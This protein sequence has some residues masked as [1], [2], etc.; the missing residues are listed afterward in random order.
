MYLIFT[1]ATKNKELKFL[2]SRTLDVAELFLWTYVDAKANDLKQALYYY[3]ILVSAG[4]MRE[5][6]TSTQ[7]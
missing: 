5:A 1:V 7:I 4:Q 2:D 6:K 3:S